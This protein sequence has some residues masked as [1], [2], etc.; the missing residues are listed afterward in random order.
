[1]TPNYRVKIQGMKVGGLLLI[2]L[3]ISLCSKSQEFETIYDDFDNDSLGW[4]ISD[5]NESKAIIKDGYYFIS[6]TNNKT[7]FFSTFIIDPNYNYSIETVFTFLNADKNSTFG[8]VW[9]N[10]IDRDFMEFL[11]NPSGYYF[12]ESMVNA[13]K[14]IVKNWHKT[15]SIKKTKDEVKLNVLKENQIIKYFIN[16]EQV[17]ISDNYPIVGTELG[18]R[19]AGSAELKVDYIKVTALK[20]EMNLVDHPINGNELQ[21]LGPKVNSI[22]SERGPVISPDGTKLYITRTHPDNIKGMETDDIWYT[23]LDEY[24]EWNELKHAGFPLNNASNNFV[25]S[26]TPDGN[27]LLLGN[28]YKKDGSPDRSGISI[29]T[30]RNGEW[31]IPLKQ[32]IEGYK[33]IDPYGCFFLSPDGTKLII[34]AENE[35]SYG[36]LDLFVSFLEGPGKWSK[37]VNLG[38]TLNTFAPDFSPF[39]A[40]DGKTLYF[41]SYGHKGYGSSDIFVTKRLDDTWQ[42][43]TVP[44]NMGFEIN[45]KGW[46]AYYCLSAKGDYAYMVS[47]KSEITYGSEDVFKIATME[48]A[49]PDPVVLVSGYAYDKKTNQRINAEIRYENLRTGKD[50]GIAHATIENGYKLVLPKGE[51]YGVRAVSEGFYAVSQNI[52]LKDLESFEEKQVSLY[53]IPIEKGLSIRLNNIF[54]DFDKATLQS[55]SFSELNRLVSVLNDNPKIKIAISGHTDSKGTE[56]YNL[57]LSDDRAK[58]V[59]QY[60]IEQG[61]D[62]NRISAKGY[63]ESKPIS[64]NDTEEGRQLNR[65]VEFTIL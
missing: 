31:Q 14:I 1:M 41:S 19:I 18:F 26:V 42:N 16:D 7:D 56:Q 5:C 59:R 46:D 38:T 2:L 52:D 11:L 54:F 6:N 17:Y 12:V 50:E 9:G 51:S 49:M 32:H 8:L 3:F 10:Y 13:R 53:L 36:D 23:T 62:Q 55:Q 4:K 28:T 25:I 39:L 61:V 45:S 27:T 34:C 40:S 37:P 22:Y 65:R 60:L 33:N 20:K 24:N 48:S 43:W 44:K 58:A 35:D 63:G 15:K 47:S 64:T 30:K 29:A 57:K 21:N